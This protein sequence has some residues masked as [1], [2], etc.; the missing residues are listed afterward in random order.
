MPLMA[1]SARYRNEDDVFFTSVNVLIMD[2]IKLCLSSAIIISNEKS[3]AGYVSDCSRAKS[4]K[5]F[6]VR[7]IV[8]DRNFWRSG[9]DHE[10]N[11]DNKASLLN[12]AI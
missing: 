4:S 5:F 8:H 11:S 1:R 6:H 9:G 7:S 2:L 12:Q 3:V 10:G